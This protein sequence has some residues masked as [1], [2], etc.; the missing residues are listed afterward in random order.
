MR[1]GRGRGRAGKPAVS[2]HLAGGLPRLF[3]TCIAQL[4]MVSGFCT[5]VHVCDCVCHGCCYSIVFFGGNR[6]VVTPRVIGVNVTE[7]CDQ[8]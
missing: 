6:A 3:S 2:A 5:F 1:C 4:Y 7:R 8:S